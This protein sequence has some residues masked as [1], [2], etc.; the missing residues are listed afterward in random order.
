LFEK[1]ETRLKITQHFTE[2]AD[3]DGFIRFYSDFYQEEIEKVSQFSAP[4]SKKYY[5]YLRE[6]GI[7]KFCSKAFLDVSQVCDN[8]EAEELRRPVIH[9]T[10]RQ[11]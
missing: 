8:L 10:V 5:F 11:E 9:T 7:D 1:V 4:I 3:F 6:A 2:L